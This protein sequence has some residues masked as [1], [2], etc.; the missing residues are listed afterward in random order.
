MEITIILKQKLEYLPPISNLIDCLID[1]NIKVNLITTELTEQNNLRYKN[2]IYIKII[3]LQNF[4][5]R[6]LKIFSIWY[7]RKIA[8]QYLEANNIGSAENSFI[9]LGSAEAAMG[10]GKKIANFK[11]IFQ[12]HELYD[13]IYHYRYT[14]GYYFKHS[15]LNICPEANRAAIFRYWYKLKVSPTV[16]PNTPFYHPQMINM[17]IED[18]EIYNKIKLLKN[19]KLILYMGVIAP[20]RDITPFI[21]MINQIGD[22]YHLILLGRIDGEMSTVINLINENNNVTYLGQMS[23]PAHLQVASWAF[24]GIL[25]YNFEDLNNIFCAPNKIWEYAGF[26]IPMISNDIP[27]MEN[28]LTKYNSGLTLN[29]ENADTE[30]IIDKIKLID[31]NYSYMSENS[32]KMYADGNYKNQLINVLKK[33]S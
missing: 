5:F 26:G 20:D 32:R 10:M 14:N 24:I 4:K 16:L 23:S 13:K 19:K 8:F 15:K 29:F 12:C 3:N 30:E 21:K 2:K 25:S 17:E 11:Y 1:L 28:L 18:V 27:G 6:P 9:W 31:S 33:L 22:N 7:F